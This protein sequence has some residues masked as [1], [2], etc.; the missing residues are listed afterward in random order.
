MG[1]VTRI[2]MFMSTRLAAIFGFMNFDIIY[3]F[4]LFRGTESR[5]GQGSSLNQT[6]IIR[7]QLPK[8]LKYIGAR[9]MLDAPCGDFHWM[10]HVNLDGIYYVGGDIVGQLIR[11]NKRQYGNKR[12][13]FCKLDVTQDFVPCVDLIFCR[14]CLVHLTYKAGLRALRNFKKSGSRFLLMTTFSRREENLDL[15]TNFWRPLNMQLA[16][17]Y[18]P[19]PICLINE[20]CTEDNN[21]YVD[22]SMGLWKLEDIIL[23]DQTD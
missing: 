14:D 13:S 16:P 4:N 2:A 12:R 10:N 15:H 19:E 7:E 6:R 23:R 20:G 11:E 17:F 21:I 3:R 8:I 18:F 22:K 1:L 5:S 9:T